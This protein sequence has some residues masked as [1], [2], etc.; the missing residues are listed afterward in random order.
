MKEDAKALASAPGFEGGTGDVPGA[1]C[2]A[3]DESDARGPG[4]NR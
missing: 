3:I 2:F 4:E 1:N